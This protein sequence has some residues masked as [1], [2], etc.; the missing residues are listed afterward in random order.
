MIDSLDNIATM[1]R[2]HVKLGEHDE[3]AKMYTSFLAQN[4]T[5]NVVSI[6]GSVNVQ[7]TLILDR[8]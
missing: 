4:A 8:V 1:F 7:C 3:A 2:L 5:Q 6:I